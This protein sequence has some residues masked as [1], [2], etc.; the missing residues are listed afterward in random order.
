VGVSD[1][2]ASLLFCQLKELNQLSRKASPRAVRYRR[3]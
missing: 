3:D 1:R 2:E